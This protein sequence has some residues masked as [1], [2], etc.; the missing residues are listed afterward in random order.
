MRGRLPGGLV[1]MPAAAFAV[2]QLRY[3]LA[4]GTH[5]RAELAAQ[6]HTY[7]HSLVPWL[8][9]TLAV[10][11]AAFVRRAAH[12]LHTGETGAFTRRSTAILWSATAVGLVAIYAVQESFEEFFA[13]GHP[14]GLGGVFG[15]GGWWAVPAAAL[16]A[17]VVV[18]AL[19]LGRTIVR[20]AGRLARRHFGFSFVPPIVPDGLVLVAA[21]PLARSAAGRAPPR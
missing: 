12:A 17:L 3:A 8:V 18:A 16:V 13:S 10:G 4:Y 1:A 14:T 2:H 19:R 21:R 15:H 11:L 7:L 5:A 9:I 20:A 6:G